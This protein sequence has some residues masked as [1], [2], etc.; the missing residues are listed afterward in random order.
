[1][2]GLEMAME[3]LLMI[4]RRTRSLEDKDRENPEAK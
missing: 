3:V 1:M 2:Q 4:R